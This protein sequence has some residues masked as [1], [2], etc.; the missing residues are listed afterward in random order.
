VIRSGPMR[1]RIR[2]ERRAASADASGDLGPWQLVDEV[3]AEVDRTPGGERWVPGAALRDA[4]VPVVFR[5][6]FRDDVTPAMRIVH[7]ERVHDVRSV[8]DPT[9]RRA[10]LVIVTDEI[11]GQTP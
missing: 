7:R 10:E 1:A 8:V 2:I 11:V 4:Q 6:R 3:W 9:D 5:C